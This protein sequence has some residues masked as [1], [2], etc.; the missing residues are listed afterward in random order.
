MSFRQWEHKVSTQC[1]IKFHPLTGWMDRTQI[2][3]VTTNAIWPIPCFLWSTQHKPTAI[4]CLLVCWA[5]PTNGDSEFAYLHHIYVF[6]TEGKVLAL[7]YFSFFNQNPTRSEVLWEPSQSW[8]LFHFAWTVFK[9]EE[10]EV[11]QERG[12]KKEM[13]GYLDIAER[14]N[15][16]MLPNITIAPGSKWPHWFI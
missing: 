14:M 10:L 9:I 2:A 4:I 6:T 5:N 3:H 12:R 16:F 15:Q 13:D 1:R 8:S 11:W 7:T